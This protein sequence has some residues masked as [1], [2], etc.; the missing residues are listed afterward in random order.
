MK[1]H[2]TKTEKYSYFVV[3]GVVILTLTLKIVL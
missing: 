1:N 2:L 3:V